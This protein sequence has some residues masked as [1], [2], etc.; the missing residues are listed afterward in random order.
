MKGPKR[1]NSDA[2]GRARAADGVEEQDEEREYRM[3]VVRGR[4]IGR[5]PHGTGRAVDD[6]CVG[7]LDD[8]D[9]LPKHGGE[10]LGALRGDLVVRRPGPKGV[11]PQNAERV[12]AV[13]EPHLR[14]PS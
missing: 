10:P 2:S 9:Q 5:A 7:G 12:V 14:A 11:V 13:G 1:R 3:P 6:V 4:R 8:E